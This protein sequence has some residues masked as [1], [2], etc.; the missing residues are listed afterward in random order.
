MGGKSKAPP[1]PDYR[2]AAE[3][4]G[5][6]SLANINAQTRANRPNVNTPFGSSQWSQDRG[7]NWTNEVTLDPAAQR[8]L[9]QQQAITEGRSN[10]AQGMIGSAGSEMQTPDDFWQNLPAAGQAPQA[11][12]IDPTVSGQI[13]DTGMGNIGPTGQGPTQGQYTPEDIQR[14][15]EGAGYNPDF[16]QTQ[17]DRQMSLMG[18]QQERAMTAMDTQLRNQGLSPGSQA[19][20]NAMGDLRNQQGEVQSRMSQDAMRL[21]ADEQQRQ[22]GRNVTQGQFGNQASQQ[23][24]A[25]QLGIGGQRYQESMGAGSFAEQQRAARGA[26]AGQQFGQEMAGA[27]MGQSQDARQ[28]AQEMAANQQQFGQGSQQFNMQNQQRQ[29]AVAEQLQREGWS[30]NKI[31]AMMSGQQVGMPQMP[32]FKSAGAGQATDYLGAANM[33]GQ[34]GMQAQQMNNALAAAPW[35]ALGQIGGGLAGGMMMSDARL[36][37]DIKPLLKIGGLD[38]VSWTWNGVLGLVGD[39]VGFVAQQ[40]QKLYPQFVQEMDNGYL[41]I[42]YDGLL[43]MEIPNG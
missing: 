32:D 38:L 3:A 13:P 37:E 39:S 33:G 12:G 35:E 18:P 11:G 27:Q 9:D 22:F 43:D 17:F 25:Q 7:G 6:S 30:L 26:E 20:D 34:Y 16:A 19:Y 8:A 28:F 5:E 36:K 1:A 24:L 42:N 15:V 4:S 21:G 10:I 29:Q 40:V 14:G 31:N 2:G 23:A 41:A